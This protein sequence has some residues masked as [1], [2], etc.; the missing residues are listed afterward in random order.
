MA[1]PELFT[2]TDG[3]QLCAVQADTFKTGRITVQMALPLA[4]DIAAKA[5]LP[6]L[7]RRSCRAYPTV[8]ALNGHLDTLYGATLGASV[9]KKGEAQI[10]QISVSAID[11][12]FAL[13]GESVSAQAAQLLM[14]LLFDP[15]LEDGTFP[16]ADVD[17]EKRLLLERMRAEDDDKRVYACRRCEEVMCEK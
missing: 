4:G 17:T 9:Q 2:I 8:T 14:Q 15:K 11:D 13:D 12:R 5:A 6:Y 1:Q 7:L 16:Q 10:L 3:V